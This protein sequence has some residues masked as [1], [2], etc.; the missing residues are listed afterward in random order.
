MVDQTKVRTIRV[1]VADDHTIVRKGIRALLM[2]EPDIEVV[3]EARDGR[4]AIA[5]AEKLKP[6]VILMD[7][8][9]P[10]MD[11]VEATRHIK[12]RQL[13]ACVLVLTSFAGDEEVFPAIKAGTQ[14][15]LLKHCS[16]EELVQAIRQVH[17]G[18]SALHPMIARKVLDRLS[19]ASNREPR[20]VP[21]TEREMDV[22]QLVARGQRNQEISDQLTISEATVRAHVSNIL[23]KLHLCS[24]TQAAIYALREGLASL[25]DVGKPSTSRGFQI[26]PPSRLA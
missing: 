2:T 6:D 19:A 26:P 24:R 23:A 14:G 4:E 5:K 16:P 7:L 9:M 20:T 25:D 8:L 11:G 15:Y 13:K 18:E 22:L 10:G 3:G 21:L 12:E 17:S 1:L